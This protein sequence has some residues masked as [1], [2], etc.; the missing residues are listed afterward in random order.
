[1]TGGQTIVLVTLGSIG[2]LLPFLA[3]G[4]GLRRRGHDVIVATHSEYESAC[5]TL[6]FG[7]RSIWDG[8]QSRGAFRDVLTRSPA[9][10]WAGVWHEFFLP[11]VEPTFAA[12][13]DLV[14]S[15]GC[16]V[17][18]AWSA[19]GAI[20]ACEASGTPLFTAYLSPH[21]GLLHE[22]EN[23]EH[24]L[25]EQ[26]RERLGVG[27]PS[28]GFEPKPNRR[29]GLFPDWFCSRDPRLAGI[30]PIGFPFHDDA[31]VPVSLAKVRCFLDAG[32]PP[33]VFT[34]GSFMDQAEDFFSAA[35]RACM[36]LDRRAIFLTPHHRQIPA[37]LPDEILH[38]DYVPLHRVLDRC[39]AIFH[40]GGIGTCA[41]ALRA[42]I[43]QIISPI[44]FD[45]FDNAAQVERL[46]VGYAIDHGSVNAGTI[47]GA[48]Q[49]ARALA[50][51]S[52][53][54]DVRA[55]FV[56]DPTEDICERIV[57]LA[58]NQEK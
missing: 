26:V 37:T 28:A 57:T 44:F 10:T 53:C 8:M 24:E 5:R 50:E 11:A 34:P 1:M 38:L 39:A 42:G 14:D 18:A 4:K 25:R 48:L 27:L 32:E 36:E 47:A 20:A 9:D 21:A 19:L 7:F 41:Q 12:V 51:Q 2:D 31:L 15:H 13:R 45:Q 46:G 33:V 16:T 6:G 29:L 58:A 55:R 52:N 23:G 43:P 49:D 30:T 3:I 54:S 35:L 40:H 56:G 22:A 17:V